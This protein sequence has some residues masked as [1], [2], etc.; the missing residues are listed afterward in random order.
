LLD[1]GSTHSSKMSTLCLTKLG[2]GFGAPL[3]QQSTLLL[4]SSELT[5]KKQ[6]R[7][8]ICNKL[9]QSATT[10]KVSLMKRK[11]GKEPMI[12]RSLFSLAFSPGHTLGESVALLFRPEK[13]DLIQSS[14]INS[15]L[16]RFQDLSLSSITGMT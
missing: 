16:L 5:A 15:S 12:T 9:L 8:L 11:A 1:I 14:E 4:S 3:M 2:N 13:I 7:L 10:L 6:S